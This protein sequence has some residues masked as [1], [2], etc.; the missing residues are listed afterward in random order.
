MAHIEQT[1]LF[2]GPVVAPDV[3]EIRILQG[4][5]VPRKG[6]HLRSPSNVQIIQLSLLDRPRG[7]R[8][9][10]APC[11]PILGVHRMAS[12][13]SG[14]YASDGGAAL[15]RTWELPLEDVGAIARNAGGL[16]DISRSQEVHTS[17]QRS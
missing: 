8:R 17:S 7:S 3:T 6:H 9:G 2:S 1:S 11:N 4:H 10:I 13:E 16:K 12:S 5:G 15:Q 14:S